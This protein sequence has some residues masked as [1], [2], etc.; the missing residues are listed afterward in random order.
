MQD[1]IPAQAPVSGM[2]YSTWTANQASMSCQGK[3][4]RKGGPSDFMIAVS[5]HKDPVDCLLA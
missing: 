4:L 2:T 1:K 5:L 3:T